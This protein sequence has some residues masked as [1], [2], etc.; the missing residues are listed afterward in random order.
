MPSLMDSLE[1]GL[2]FIEF[3]G[4]RK[5]KTDRKELRD[6]YNLE[7]KS[8]YFTMLVTPVKACTCLLLIFTYVSRAIAS[9]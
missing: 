6:I 2:D 7:F 4:E 8:R 3:L 5:S 1:S 9:L